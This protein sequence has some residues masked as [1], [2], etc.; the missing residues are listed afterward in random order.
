MS[1]PRRI[2]RPPNSRG[3]PQISIGHARHAP[4][5]AQPS[6]RDGSTGKSQ[7]HFPDIAP[8]HPCHPKDCI[9]SADPMSST[10]PLV[11]DFFLSFFSADYNIAPIFSRLELYHGSSL[12]EQ[13]HEV[14][15][16]V[17]LWHDMTGNI[18][19]HGTT[20]SLLEGQNVSSTLRSGEAI[21]GGGGLPPAI[22]FPVESSAFHC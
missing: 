9:P 11:R 13:I 16:L 20:S 12:L 2:A 10:C 18:V 1:H 7:K 8:S 22:T 5:R 4:R 21:P 19:A 6:H 3:P 17:N 15:F 14:G